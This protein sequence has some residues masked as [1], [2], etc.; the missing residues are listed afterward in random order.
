MSAPWQ[1]RHT[2]A[3]VTLARTMYGDGEGWTPTEIMRYLREQGT[4]VSMQTIRRWVI[5]GEDEK[6]KAEAA[7]R[8]ERKRRNASGPLLARMQQ[9]HKA[10]LSFTAIAVLVDLDYGVKIT[11][12]QARY[13]VRHNRDPRD[14]R[15]RRTP[16]SR[17]RA[18]A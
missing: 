11:S 7:A 6:C 18:S 10:G 17:A 1:R 5:P 2:M 15:P 12:E 9:L 13:C 14:L 8:R 16:L 4:D 3:T